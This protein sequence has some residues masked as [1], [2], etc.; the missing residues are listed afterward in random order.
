[1]EAT[2]GR[3]VRS[4]TADPSVWGA[5]DSVAEAAVFEEAAAGSVVVADS[6]A[7]AGAGGNWLIEEQT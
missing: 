1:V 4:A 3:P 6:V 7:A 5:A 2:P